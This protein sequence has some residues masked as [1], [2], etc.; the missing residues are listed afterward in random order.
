MDKASV[1]A[2]FAM[3]SPV[4][5]GTISWDVEGKVMTFEPA[6]QF[7][8][9]EFVEARIGA[10]AKSADGHAMGKAKSISFRVMQI[11]TVD[12]YGVAAKD[13]HVY[14]P[15]VMAIK[16]VDSTSTR[17]NV[18]TWQRGFLTFDLSVLPEDLINITD[19]N[20]S[21][22]QSQADA[23]A[24]GA[25]TGNLRIESLVY[26]SLDLADFNKK[27]VEFCWPACAPVSYLLS[28]SS[29]IGVKSADVILFV[30][31]DW[32]KRNEQ[33]HLSQYRLRFE[34]ENNGDGPEI[35][36]E[37]HSSEGA[38]KPKLRITYTHP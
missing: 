6:A 16:K 3:V 31:N 14:S 18:G 10:T 33:G 38:T 36:A 20:L 37:F 19:T 15:A 25:A 26:G 1:N 17:F 28:S 23:T 9:G 24:Y 32:E 5:D 30:K 22:M 35:S 13:G 7:D 12:I 2:A 21:V 8:Y 4:V 27:G 29:S 11:K 34:K